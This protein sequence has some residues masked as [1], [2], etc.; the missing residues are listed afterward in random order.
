MALKTTVP[1]RPMAAAPAMP[2]VLRAAVNG[3]GRNATAKPAASTIRAVTPPRR[4]AIG[5]SRDAARNATT[6]TAV[7]TPSLAPPTVTVRKSDRSEAAGAAVADMDRL[8]SSMRVGAGGPPRKSKRGL[9][10]GKHQQDHEIG[11]GPRGERPVHPSP[12]AGRGECRATPVPGQEQRQPRD[13]RHDEQPCPDLQDG[14]RPAE[15]RERQRGARDREAEA[16]PQA[17]EQ[18]EGPVAAAAIFLHLIQLSERIEPR[19]QWAE[20]E[21]D[22]GVARVE[23]T[24]RGGPSGKRRERPEAPHVD[25][26]GDARHRLEA[27]RRHRVENRQHETDGVRDPERGRKREA[28]QLTAGEQRDAEREQV[29]RQWGRRIQIADVTFVL[30]EYGIDRQRAAVQEHDPHYE[31][32]ERRR[33]PLPAPRSPETHGQHVAE[34]RVPRHDRPLGGPQVEHVGEDIA[35]QQ[36]IAPAAPGV[37]RAGVDY[38]FRPSAVA[39]MRSPV[40]VRSGCTDSISRISGATRLARPPV[41]MT[42]GVW[43]FGHSALMRRTIPSTASAVPSSTPERIASSVRRPM[44]REGGVRSVAGSLAVPRMSASDAVRMPGMITPG[45]RTASDARSEEHTSELQ[46]PCN[47]VCRLLLEKKK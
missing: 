1:T 15:Q 20:A 46:S 2:S 22:E 36:P 42:C 41:A 10:P 28:D 12:V 5:T 24:A 9:S 25:P 27:E 34:H 37:Q 33:Q 43:P 7:A 32:E 30:V 14:R 39:A 23:R 40:R 47:L 4:A 44:V 3:A 45:I 8:S 38:H 21:Q 31:P 18:G 29:A 19:E 26:P 16:R 11:N 35:G 13:E 17:Q 6:A